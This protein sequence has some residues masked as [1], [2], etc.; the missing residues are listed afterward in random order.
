MPLIS[1][2][3][4]DKESP[5]VF[6]IGSCGLLSNESKQQA[7]SNALQRKRPKKNGSGRLVNQLNTFTSPPPLLL[8]DS[9]KVA[10]TSQNNSG[11]AGG[12]SVGFSA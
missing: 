3:S 6:D 5:S 12:A 4:S 2:I 10:I 7:A 9:P 11:V 8:S 1:N